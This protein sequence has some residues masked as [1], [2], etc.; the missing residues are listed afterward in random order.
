MNSSYLQ[1]YVMNT[2]GTGLQQVAFTGSTA[3]N[4]DPVWSPDGTQITFGSDR[5]GGNRLNVFTMNMDGSQVRQ[6]T[7]FDV[8]YEAANPNWSSDGRKISFQYDINGN[9]QSNPNAFAAVWTMNADG[10][11]AI[12]TGVQCSDVGCDPTWQPRQYGRGRPRTA[13]G[14]GV[15]IGR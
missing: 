12:N 8:P 2:D 3:N 1:I 15:C 7:Y 4:G 14:P 13:P 11:D 9:K 5:E 10:S 6:L